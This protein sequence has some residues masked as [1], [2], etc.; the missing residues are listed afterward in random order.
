LTVSFNNGASWTLPEKIT[1]ETPLRDWRY[2]SISPNNDVN[3]NQLSVQMVCQSDS[4]AGCHVVGSSPIGMSEY[5]GIRYST[6]LN[7]L[8]SNPILSSPA[9]GATNVELTPLLDWNNS[10]NASSYRLQLSKF[11]NFATVILDI[12]GI[13]LSQY[14]VQ[15]LILTYDTVYH[16]RVIASNI[17]GNS[18]WSATFNFRTVS[19]IPL[20]PVLLSPANGSI[21]NPLNPTMDW[22]SVINADTYNI[23]ISRNTDFTQI[24]LDVQNISLS[25]YNVPPSTLSYDSIYFWRVRGTNAF[26]TGQWSSVWNF[27]TISFLPYA[28]VLTSPLNN[29]TN[30]SLTPTLDWNDVFGANSYK[31]Q[32]S[33]DS[34]FSTFILN[35]SNIIPSQYVIPP[36]VLNYSSKYYWR[37]NASNSN[38][39]GQYSNVWNFSTAGVPLTPTLTSPLNGAEG[40]V[41]TPIL[42]WENTVGAIS[43]KVQVATDS[44]FFNIIFDQSNLTT[45][46]LTIPSPYLTYS[47]RYFWRVNATNSVGTGPWSSVWNFLTISIP[48]PPA[49]VLF[50]PAN[51]SLGVSVTP[52]LDWSTI[53]I[54]EKYRVNIATDLNFN[55]II[56]DIDTVYAS[57][58]RVPANVLGYNVLYFWRVNA[59]NSS[60]T[61]SW[62]STWVFR[63][64]FTNIQLFSFEIPKDYK[65]YENYPNP[66]NPSTKIRFDLPNSAFVK[67]KIY[68][69]TG[70]E[71]NELIN[72]YLQAGSYVK[73]FSS[74]DLP[75]GVY[76]YKLSTKDFT[77][78]KRMVVIK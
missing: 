39:Q 77:A 50:S 42:D 64:G 32:L 21:N 8:P 57:E 3:N 16:W 31:L 15:P 48:I 68:A 72:E 54:A 38:G 17:N 67:L 59:S 33:T 55:N 5:V 44:I 28:P 35:I 58:F 6:G 70:R 26:A 40:V 37:I 36:T 13:S 34:N 30:I 11:S 18:E 43:Y 71:L 76:F 41:I 10:S 53:L 51:N 56:Y 9:N 52:L 78:V 4:I 20:A 23:Q 74:M 46:Q 27:R 49:P 22:N 19:N 14:Q 63:T 69:L 7:S 62:S 45:S 73:E 60:G 61:G 24:L 2:I 1:P 65:L 25:Q 29:S 12:S 66:F 75:S 47:S